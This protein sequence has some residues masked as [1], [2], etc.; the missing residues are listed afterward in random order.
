MEEKEN[1]QPLTKF[2][3]GAVASLLDTTKELQATTSETYEIQQW[4]QNGLSY[5][6]DVHGKWERLKTTIQMATLVNPNLNM[7]G[8][9]RDLDK[10][11]TEY[12]SV[13][14]AISLFT[15][16]MMK[17]EYLSEMVNKFKADVDNFLVVRDEV[18]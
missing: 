11:A 7:R 14:N 17:E 8:V 6:L 4:I 16:G 1:A 5:F 12:E 9:A 13:T 10:L 3:A 15:K 2:I 18:K